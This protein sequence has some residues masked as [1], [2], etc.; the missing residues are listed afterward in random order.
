MRIR[1]SLTVSI[2][3]IT[4]SAPA[5]AAPPTGWYLGIEGG[6]S[7]NSDQDA[8]WTQGPF[9]PVAVE[10]HS[11]TGWAALATAG[12]RFHNN[13]RIEGEAGYR[14]ND[15]TRIAP[16]T[17]DAG[18]KTNAVTLMGNLFYDMPVTDRFSLSLGAG[19]GAIRS[20]F[21]DGLFVKD[22]ATKFAYQGLAEAALAVSP[23]MDL[24]L[25]YR[26][27][28]SNGSRFDGEGPLYPETYRTDSLTN[29]T[30]TLGL[31]YDLYP[32]ERH[33]AAAEPPPVHEVAAMPPATDPAAPKQF[34]VFFGFN[35]SNLTTEAH[36][37]IAEAAETARKTGSASIAVI[38]HA[39]TVG[40]K[41][42]NQT[43]SERRANTVRSDLVANGIAGGM[44]TTMG[45]GE[46]E[47]L[48][49]TGDNVKEPQN[50]RA[51]ID[52]K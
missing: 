15:I 50:R 5:F 8:I 36:R 23:R 25:S 6:G 51:T 3:A 49:Q 9:A 42:D 19:A 48:V 4:V 12:Y 18:G 1:L 32:D 46:A 10:V 14:H 11:D 20:R 52:L 33:T 39:D 26:Y 47:L 17:N 34:L 13:W 22:E 28:R 2:L 7:R 31:R 16:L 44:I 27:L 24:T 37:V 43:L 38:G 29:Q 35:K 45:R 30:L 40:S 21:Y 41:N